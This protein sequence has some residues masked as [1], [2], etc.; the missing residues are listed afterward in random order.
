MSL[1]SSFDVNEMS[2]NGVFDKI[3]ASDTSNVNDNYFL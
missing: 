2:E 3:L 1:V